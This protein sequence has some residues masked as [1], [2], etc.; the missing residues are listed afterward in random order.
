MSAQRM[1]AGALLACWAVWFAPSAR[2]QPKDTASRDET[3]SMRP[4]PARLTIWTDRPG[5]HYRDLVQAYLAIDPGRDRRRYHLFVY[6]EH[7][8]TGRR[9]Y[10]ARSG[11]RARLW[12]ADGVATT[13]GQRPFLSGAESIPEW[14]AERIW[15]QSRMGRGLWQFVAELRSPDTTEVVKRAHAKFVVTEWLPEV[16]GRGGRAHLISA[17]TTWSR[18]RVRALRGPVLVQAGATLA[19][20]PGTVVLGRGPQAA[21]VVEQGGRIEARGRPEAPVVMSCDAPAGERFA[22]CWGGLALLGSAPMSRGTDWAAGVAPEASAA[23]G[24]SDAGD[25]SGVL[26]YVRVE[27][28]GAASGAAARSAGIGLYG[29]GSG[30]RIDHLQAHASA[31][32]GILFSGGTA[33]CSH[34]VSSASGGSALAWQLGW[35][36][37]AQHVYLQ[38]DPAAGGCAIDGANDGQAFDALPRS[39]PVLYNL[40]LASGAPQGELSPG[41]GIL[42]RSGSAITARNVIAV[43]FR[44]GS[45]SLRDNA[46]SLFLD[47]TS[48]ISAA[49]LYSGRR[50]SGGLQGPVAHQD[51]DPMLVSAAHRPNPDPRP[52]LDSPALKFAMGAVPPS[53]GLLDTGAQYIGAFGDSNWLEE[54]TF[55]GPESD[56]GI[57]EDEAAAAGN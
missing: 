15:S 42:L 8:G 27:F 21:V 45:V 57:A 43:G 3:A 44:S 31:G 33:G 55:F 13:G 38:Q 1:L 26:E 51:V 20:E 47:G 32:E 25:S 37:T 54:W 30:T 39:A 16:L 18:D 52:R 35:R 40:T 11:D 5:Y 28:A 34:C 53:D 14:P 23:Y 41:C 22:G 2:C 50:Q 36:G 6:L 10:L 29:V 49:I 4:T 24:G 12:P 48:S 56:Y 46:E 9:H 7:P 17:D 19:I